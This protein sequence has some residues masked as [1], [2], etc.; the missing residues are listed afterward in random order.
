MIISS[1]SMGGLLSYFFN[2]IFPSIAVQ[3]QTT[4]YVLACEQDKYYVGSTD[5]LEQRLIAHR[6]GHGSAW[7]KKYP[8]L[9]CLSTKPKTSIFDEDNTTKELMIKYSI[10]NVRGGSYVQCILSAAQIECLSIELSSAC[11]TCF[12]CK[13]QGHYIKNCPML[14]NNNIKNNIKLYCIKCHRNNH[15]VENCYAKTIFTKSINVN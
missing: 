12:K 9:G 3:E 14:K 5:N 7:T 13:Q 6:D 11:N 10:E 1:N 4:I 8:P 2:L 15:N